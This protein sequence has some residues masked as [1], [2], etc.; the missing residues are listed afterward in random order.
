MAIKTVQEESLTAIGDAIRAKAGGQGPLVFPQGMVEAIESIEAKPVI[1]PII[2]TGNVSY[3][4]CGP[5]AGEYIK[6]FGESIS[7]TSITTSS[8]LFYESPLSFIPFEINMKETVDQNMTRMFEKS[9]IQRLPKINYAS[10]STMS[11]MFSECKYLREIPDGWG[12]DWNWDEIHAYQYG[13]MSAIFNGCYS[14]RKISPSFLSNLWGKQTSQF[15][16]ASTFTYCVSLDEITNFPVGSSIFIA[17]S[18]RFSA[19]V[20]HCY[21]LKTLTFETDE[22]NNPK[23]VQ[24]KNQTIDLSPQYSL[25]GIGFVYQTNRNYVLDY[26]SGI[27]ADKEVKD[28]A[29]YQALKNDPDWFSYKKEYSRYNHDSAVETIN[30]LP[31][32]SAYLATA[33]GTN[34]I[35]FDG[36]SGAKTDGGA[37]NTL[38]AEE[39]AVATAKGWTVSLV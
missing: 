1:E 34:T 31:D 38:T 36:G 18:N 14:L 20:Q 10:P 19:F 22:M 11:S 35:K 15:P 12:E 37:I 17:T 33:G 30:S 16:T 5:I 8:Y 27:T 28:D 23:T 9:K 3:M 39:I 4:C 21:R 25:Y 29:T 6:H 7:T 26:N 24:W 32:A 13:Y 2:L